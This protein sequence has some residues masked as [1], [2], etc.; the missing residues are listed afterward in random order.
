MEPIDLERA[1]DRLHAQAGLNPA[2]PVVPV[3]LAAE[4]FGWRNV[5]EVADLADVAVIAGGRLLLRAGESEARHDWHA[6]RAL[7]R[8]NLGLLRGSFT[9]A[10]VDSLAAAIRTPHRAF[11]RYARAAGP[12]FVDLARAFSI[13]ESAAAL[14][15]G[16]V[17]GARVALFAPDRPVRVRGRV[18]S[19][20]RRSLRLSDAPG[21]FVHVFVA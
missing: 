5:E 10:A 16:E 4:L 19:A 12:A 18:R 7:A 2:D 15:F 6:A 9:E 11:E 1:A 20:R 17:T 3:H 21:R 14:R 8:W 13:S